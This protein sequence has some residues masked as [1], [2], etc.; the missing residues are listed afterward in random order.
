MF[1]AFKLSQVLKEMIHYKLDLLG[2]FS[3][4]SSGK[5]KAVY[6]VWEV[7]CS[8]KFYKKLDLIFTK[9]S[10]CARIHVFYIFFKLY[11]ISLS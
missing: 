9:G 4:P 3:W 1:E 5:Y 11:I 6:S 7:N 2:L 10:Y 8:G